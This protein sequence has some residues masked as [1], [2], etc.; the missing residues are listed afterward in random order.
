[1]KIT[2]LAVLAATALGGA[3][4]ALAVTGTYTY[5][6]QSFKCADTPES[7][8][9]KKVVKPGHLMATFTFKQD[10]VQGGGDQTV[11]SYVRDVSIFSSWTITDGYSTIGAATGGT[12]TAGSTFTFNDKTIP[13]WAWMPAGRRARS[14]RMPRSISTR[15]LP[16]TASPMRTA[17]AASA[18][19]RVPRSAACPN[20]PPGRCSPPTSG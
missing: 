5:T 8:C 1:M 14:R 2:A 19:A 13:T 4:P 20:L 18:P 7:S 10:F 15:R 17:T 9:V 16:R 12:F 3:V 11:S 6:G